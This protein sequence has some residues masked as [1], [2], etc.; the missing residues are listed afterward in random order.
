MRPANPFEHQSDGR[1]ATPG[2]AGP[3]LDLNGNGNVVIQCKAE[4]LRV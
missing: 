4:A 2:I 3:Q 1:N